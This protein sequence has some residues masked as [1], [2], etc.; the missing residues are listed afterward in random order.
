M[1]WVRM[2][3]SKFT[4][5][6]SDTRRSSARRKAQMVRSSASWAFSAKICTQPTSRSAMMSEWSFQM[7]MGALS[8]RL[9]TVMTM[10]RRMAEAMKTISC[11]SASPCEEVAVKVRAPVA[12]VP[13]QTDMAECSLSTG[14]KAASSFP[15]ATSSLR[16]STMWVW[17]VMG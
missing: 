8:A 16:C 5:T 1:V 7:L 14:T 3:P 9:A 12:A 6:G 4:I 13:Q 2:K 11:M 10:G 15:S 17:G